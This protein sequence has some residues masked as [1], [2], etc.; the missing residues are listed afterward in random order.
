M[1][2]IM[3][4]L[5]LDYVYQD[6]KYTYK[7]TEDKIKIIQELDTILY[8]IYLLLHHN[9][10]YSKYSVQPILQ[11]IF[12]KIQWSFQFYIELL[13][14]QNTATNLNMEKII[15]N[16]YELFLFYFLL[17]PPAKNEIYTQSILF[18]SYFL[19]FAFL[20]ANSKFYQDQLTN[21]YQ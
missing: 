3:Q 12:T 9:I 14:C 19:R 15:Y 1:N 13:D 10:V 16:I 2:H 20:S 6:T 18:Y 7:K 8:E 5:L 17:L 4:N 21:I 11:I